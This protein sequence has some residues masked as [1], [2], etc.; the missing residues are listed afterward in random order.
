MYIP[1]NLRLDCALMHKIRWD[2]LQYIYSV[3]RHG[4]LSAAA[5]ELGVNHATVLRRITALEAAQG[6]TLFDRPPGGYRLRA[7]GRDLLAALTSMG[8]TVEHLERVL[9]TLG[10]GLEGSFRITTTDS[11]AEFLM[12]QYLAALQRVHPEVQVEL[13]V[14]NMSMDPK[15][16]DAEISLRPAKKL[17]DWLEGRRVAAM[18]MTGY[19][20]GNVARDAN[21]LALSGPIL[22]SPLGEWQA[23]QPEETL[24]LK[25]D[26]F[27]T[28]ARMADAGLGRVML[29]NFIGAA[30]QTLKP[31]PGARTYQTSIWAAAHPDM[32]RSERVLVAIDFFAN[33]LASDPRLPG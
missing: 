24:G 6:V 1:Y 11:I 33:A 20:A 23:E 22:R 29:P 15:H 8:E 16:P 9:P 21:W 31:I 3:A 19:K 4:A 2:D 25:A 17:P 14:S 18:N 7:E 26:S 28:L 30:F 13:V 12:P 32:M 5:R 10:K 27:C